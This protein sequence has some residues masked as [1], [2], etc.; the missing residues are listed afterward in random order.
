MKVTG[1]KSFVE[2]HIKNVIV[3]LELCKPRILLNISV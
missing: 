1:K 2:S 3:D